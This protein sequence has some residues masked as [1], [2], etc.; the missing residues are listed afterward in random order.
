MKKNNT[1]FTLIEMVVVMGVMALLLPTIFGV[2]Y[3]I[4]QQQLQIHKLTETKKQGDLIM[5]YMKESIGRT[6]VGIVDDS[7]TEQC[8][9]PG[10]PYSSSSGSGFHFTIDQGSNPDMFSFQESSGELIF[11]EKQYNP[12]LGSYDTSTISLNN[13]SVVAVSNFLIECQRRTADVG[14]INFY[15]LV[16]FQFDATFVD[17]TPTAQEGV[18]SLHYHTKVKLRRTPN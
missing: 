8:V 9:T 13:S 7:G 15:P 4:M 2:T 14:T 10:A 11:T 17:T 5:S 12:S 1:G 6:A 3:I 16:G 18:T